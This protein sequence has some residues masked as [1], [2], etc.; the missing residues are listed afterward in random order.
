MKFL[1]IHQNFPGQFINLAAEL[2]RKKHEVTALTL[3]QRSLKSS[4]NGV[5]IIEYSLGRGN[6]KDIF[7]MVVDFETKAIRG[8]YC[9]L[10]AKELK[11][12]GYYPDV[13]IS[14]PIIMQFG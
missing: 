9:F 13:I 8:A 10:K 4:W 12:E 14:H 11:A 7:P 5:K 3:N 2:A 6:G 1:F